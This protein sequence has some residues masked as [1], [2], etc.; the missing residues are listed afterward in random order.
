[1]AIWVWALGKKIIGPRYSSGSE[2]EPF[3]DYAVTEW[4]ISVTMIEQRDLTTFNSVTALPAVTSPGIAANTVLNRSEILTMHSFAPGMRVVIRGEDWL[5]R[6]VDPSADGGYLLRCHGLPK[7]VNGKEAL[8]LTAL[9]GS[10]EIQDSKATN[11]VPDTT[12]KHAAALS[13]KPVWMLI[14]TMKDWCS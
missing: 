6:R 11:L 3:R 7:L 13:G 8:F 10:I 9:E 12:D 2:Y 1:M 14:T 4:T 5:I